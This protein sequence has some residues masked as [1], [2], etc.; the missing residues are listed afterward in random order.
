MRTY[1]NDVDPNACLWL[2][3]LM[4]ADLI[5]QGDVDGRSISDVQPSDLAGYDQC[6]FFSGI[7]GWARALQ[8][9]GVPDL[10]CWTGSCPCPS[11][12][13]AGQGGGFEDPRGRL[14]EELYR[15][16]RVCRPPII[17][18]EQVASAIA[19]GWWD[20]VASD[21]EAEGYSAAAV[22]LGAHSAGAPH[23]RQRLYWAGV[24]GDAS[25]DWRQSSP[26]PAGKAREHLVAERPSEAEGFWDRCDWLWCEDGK[27]RPVEPRTQPLVDGVSRRMVYLRGYGNAIV[28]QTA[29]AFVRA[30]LSCREQP[31]KH[32]AH[33]MNPASLEAIRAHRFAKGTSGNPAGRP[34]VRRYPPDHAGEVRFSS[35]RQQGVRLGHPRSRTSTGS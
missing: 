18:G 27:S 5:T 8:L 19:Y 3:D 25:G 15:L 9:A 20:L 24:L 6:H 34:P 26:P 22:V 7:A 13:A 28:P 10:K 17:L 29:T 2:K 4:A 31:R 30:V 35:N 23:K 21:L 1:Y 32:K 12:S 33:R 11:F 16:A 14:W